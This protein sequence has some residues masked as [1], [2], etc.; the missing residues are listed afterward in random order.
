MYTHLFFDVD[1]TLLDFAAGE[2]HSLTALFS[3]L[4]LAPY[5]EV[6]MTYSQ[7]NRA[8]WD[9]SERGEIGVEA[10]MSARFTQLLA[11]F[12]LAGDGQVLDDLFRERLADEDFSVPGVREVLARLHTQYTIAIATNGIATTQQ[13]R[14]VRAGLWQY[15]DASFVSNEIGVQ[16]PDVR[17]FEPMLALSGFSK[18]KGL[19]IG[20]SLSSDM[21]GAMRFGMPRCWYNPKQKPL[22]DLPIH[23]IISDYTELERLL[24]WDK[25]IR[26]CVEQ[27][28][29]QRYFVGQA[30]I[31]QKVEGLQ[32]MAQKMHEAGFLATTLKEADIVVTLPEKTTAEM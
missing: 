17:F 22:P 3:S 16:K 14:L 28:G 1:D 18:A 10:L 23:Y 12:H 2:H 4:A 21:T 24:A 7:I 25:P 13:K 15:V 32:E 5:D 9:A 26:V 20:D 27:D 31:P 30:E 11:A 29:V 6:F 19:M 8:L